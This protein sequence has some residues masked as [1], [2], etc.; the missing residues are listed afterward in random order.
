MNQPHP[1]VKKLPQAIL[2]DYDGVLVASEPIHGM[3]WT[4]L[5]LS[6]GL[7]QDTEI[8]NKNIG[9]TAPQTLKD[10]LDRHR[11][12]W[13]PKEVDLEALA[14]KKND[15][16]L[17]FCK[18][19]LNPYPGVRSGIQWLQSQGIQRAIVSNS[20]RRELHTTLEQLNLISAFDLIVSRDDVGKSKPDP[21]PYAFALSQLKLAPEQCIALE[22][23]PSG[24]SACLRAGIPSVGILSSFSYS[25]LK[26]PVADQ[27]ELEPFRIEKSMEDFFQWL[28]QLPPN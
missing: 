15:F 18:T 11:P 6:L 26:Q 3:A 2:F 9:K 19:R 23:S 24:L 16:Y 17:E 27:A 14:R 7:P 4:Q 20:K 10:L 1:V 5:L 21:T 28:R 25:E 22:D 13:N 8:L 12:G